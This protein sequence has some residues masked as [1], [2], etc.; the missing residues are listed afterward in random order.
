MWL[1]TVKEFIVNEGNIKSCNYKLVKHARNS[2]N[3]RKVENSPIL[4]Q[5]LLVFH[6]IC[7]NSYPMILSNYT[8]FKWSFD[9][10]YRNYHINLSLFPSA[11]LFGCMSIHFSVCPFIH[12]SLRLSCQEPLWSILVLT[13]QSIIDGLH[14]LVI[15]AQAWY[16]YSEDHF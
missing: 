13:G 1:F 10:V 9:G 12:L 7:W 5:M 14:L 16:E 4:V 6:A 3:Q 8:P 15:M 2:S 11:F